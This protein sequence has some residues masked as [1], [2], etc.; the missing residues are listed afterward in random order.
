MI[1]TALRRVRD[2]LGPTQLI[3]FGLIAAGAL[4]L[5]FVLQPLE[6]RHAALER[7]LAQGA[8]QGSAMNPELVRASTAEAKLAAFYGFFETGEETTDTLA[9]LYGI[10]KA[11]G[12]ELDAAEYRMEAT[13]ARLQRY[14][15]ALPLTGSYSQIRAFLKNALIEIPTLSLDQLTIRRERADETLARAEASLTLYL[16]QREPS[17]AGMPGGETEPQRLALPGTTDLR[18]GDLEPGRSR[19]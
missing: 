15:I 10:G 18:S 9:K 3:A 16:P 17:P 2:E 14:R 6:A 4:F 5:A 19:E 7:Q 1:S 11:V 13:Q 8:W 12:I